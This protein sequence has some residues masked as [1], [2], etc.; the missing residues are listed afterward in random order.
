[1]KRLSR[2]TMTSNG[3]FSMYN[4]QVDYLLYFRKR[5]STLFIIFILLFVSISIAGFKPLGILLYNIVFYIVFFFA[6][7]FYRVNYTEDN[8]LSLIKQLN[9][10]HEEIHVLNR[11]QLIDDSFNLAKAG[12]LN[13]KIPMNFTD[14]LEK[15]KDI[16]PWLTVMNSLNYVLNRMRRFKNALEDVEVRITVFTHIHILYNN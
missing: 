11:A 3:T 9:D 8:W 2:S 7:G 1:M 16:I 6:L 4:Q 10:S 5:L 12:L 14:Y 15:E 13:Y